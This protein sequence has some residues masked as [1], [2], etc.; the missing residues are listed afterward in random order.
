MDLPAVQAVP[1]PYAAAP[2]LGDEQSLLSQLFMP[3][4]LDGDGAQALGERHRWGPGHGY[5]VRTRAEDGMRHDFLEKA[6]PR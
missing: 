5:W 4:P 6:R 3:L 1:A 2:P